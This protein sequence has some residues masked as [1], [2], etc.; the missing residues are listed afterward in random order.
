MLGEMKYS[1]YPFDEIAEA[2]PLRIADGY[3]FYQKF[4]CAKCGQRLTMD[5]K[6]HLFDSGTCDQCGHETNIKARGCNYLLVKHE[7]IN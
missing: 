1:D 2:M 5:V 7:P 6:N 3:D 4:T